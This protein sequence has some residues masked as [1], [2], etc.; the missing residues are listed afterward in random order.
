MKNEATRVKIHEFQAKVILA[1]HGVP[2]PRGFAV[3][4][5]KQA[6]KAARDLGS[7]AVVKAQI[8]AGGRGKGRLVARLNQTAAMYA[9]LEADPT[10][11][12]GRIK[13]TPVGGIRLVN[14]PTQAAAEAKKIPRPLSRLP[15][16]RTPRP[17]GP[18]PSH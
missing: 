18:A 16:N 12:E 14:T 9:K 17:Q 11:N 3:S 13:G 1:Q 5:V 2:I 8:H 7:K 15:P 4:T 6:E 10:A